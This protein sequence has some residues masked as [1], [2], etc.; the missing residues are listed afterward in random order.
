MT[1]KRLTL[2]LLLCIPLLIA[3]GWRP[4]A[5]GEIPPT[6]PEVQ[7]PAT[8]EPLAERPEASEEGP[9][10]EEPRAAAE[11]AVVE[12]GPDDVLAEAKLLAEDVAS[13]L[14]TLEELDTRLAAQTITLAEAEAARVRAEEKPEKVRKELQAYRDGAV[15]EQQDYL[16]SL[17]ERERKN[18]KYFEYRAKWAKVLDRHSGDH[19][20]EYEQNAVASARR[21]LAEAEKN[22]KGFV[23]Y[24]EF[25]HREALEKALNA[26]SAEVAFRR[27][28]L[29]HEQATREDLLRRREEANL[30]PA[31]QKAV[32]ALDDAVRLA[33]SGAVAEAKGRLDEA[34]D[35]WGVEG[36]RRSAGASEAQLSR[37]TQAASGLRPGPDPGSR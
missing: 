27:Q 33:N 36:E 18:V 19:R 34:R 17:V 5:S 28:V 21:Q 7:A 14:A 29:L 23:E 31:E 25:Q 11:V 20:S 37:V 12:E 3:F 30:S 16:E 35:L 2:V 9:T 4:D 24:V 22:L 6:D 26:A 32:V 1:L 13:R 10:A 8:A 15:Q